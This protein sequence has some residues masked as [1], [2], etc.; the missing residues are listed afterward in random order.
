MKFPKI[1]FII[2]SIVLAGCSNVPV[3]QQISETPKNVTIFKNTVVSLT[4]DDGA[5]D[6][7]D[8]RSILAQN[9]L[10]A[11][12]YVVSGFTGMDGYMT[13]EQLR[14]LYEDGN[15]IGGHSLDHVNLT[16]ISGDDLKKEICQDYAN[17]MDYGF[18]VTSFAY[19]F[20]HYDEEA[21]Q[22]VIDCGYASARG[23]SGGPETIPPADKYALRAMPYIVND[24]SVTKM[25]RYITSVEQEGG[26]WAIFV[27][28]RVCDGCSQY[29]V[30]LDTFSKFAARIADQKQNGL[31][32][33]TIDEVIN[34][35]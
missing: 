24:T 27:F 15:E 19:P 22:A 6:N 30:D 14:G 4:F 10:H 3:T 26:G 7:Y 20:G 12:F 18:R 28:H 33:K 16:E 32:I 9:D 8:V 35:K 11:T 25:M 29:T 1:L 17:L 31:V 13:E 34:G 21:K 5:A 2:F 23:V